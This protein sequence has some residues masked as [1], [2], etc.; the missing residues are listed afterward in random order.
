MTLWCFLVQ[1]W[2]GTHFL[3]NLSGYDVDC[4]MIGNETW[5]FANAHRIAPKW[6][7]KIF[8]RY[9]FA[10][11]RGSTMGAL[12]EAIKKFK[13]WSKAK[14]VG[15][16]VIPDCKRQPRDTSE[17]NVAVVGCIFEKK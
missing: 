7:R 13:P 5:S 2:D 15:C 3:E 1:K 12:R 14:E 11:N 4:A 9:G 8:G 6:G 17:M 10:R 16:S